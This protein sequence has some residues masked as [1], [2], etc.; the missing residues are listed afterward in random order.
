MCPGLAQSNSRLERIS[1]GQFLKFCDDKPSF[2]MLPTLNN[3]QDLDPKYLEAM[4][5]VK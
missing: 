3:P 4:L 2:A 1:A 5:P